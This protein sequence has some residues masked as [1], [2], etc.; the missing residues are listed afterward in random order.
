[1]LRIKSEKKES[2]EILT[3]TNKIQMQMMQQKQTK[4]LKIATELF[5]KNGYRKTSLQMI[6]RQTGGSFATVYNIFGNKENLFRKVVEFNGESFIESLNKSFHSKFS[7]NL[8]LEKYFYH[9]GLCLIHEILSAQN[10]ALMRLIILEGYDNP[11]IV[12]IFN[13]TSD[14]INSYFVK[15]IEYYKNETNLHIN[16][17]EIEEC[18]RILIHLVIEPYWF[19]PL[20]DSNY[21]PPKDSEIEYALKRAIKIFILYLKNYKEMK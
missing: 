6:V 21:Q 14:V 4:I 8:D 11:E 12:T 20:M 5:L 18:A 19:R 2:Q 10:I 9:I 13:Q 16:K 3:K 15:G 7:S 1:M 17:K